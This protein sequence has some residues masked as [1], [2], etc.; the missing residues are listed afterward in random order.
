MPSD[1]Y[2][3]TILSLILLGMMCLVVLVVVLVSGRKEKPKETV[4][5]DD[6]I[7]KAVEWWMNALRK[8]EFNAMTS[9]DRKNPVNQPMEMAELLAISLRK[10]VSDDQVLAFGVELERILREALASPSKMI[11]GEVVLAVDYGPNTLLCEALKAAGIQPRMDVL[12]WKTT[13]TVGPT[14]VAVKS[15]YG[16]PYNVIA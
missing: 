7:A 8:P 9:E 16:Q 1:P 11:N 13:M 10:D 6:Q 14:K 12:P 3:F 4:M 2:T 15:G 5:T